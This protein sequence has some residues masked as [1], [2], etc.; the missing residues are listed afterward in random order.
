MSRSTSSCTCYALRNRGALRLDAG[1]GVRLDDRLRTRDQHL[2]FALSD[3]RGL[4]REVAQ[5]VELGATDAA[6]ANHLD[7]GDHGAVHREDA[8]DTNAARDLADGERGAHAAAAPGDA[9]TFESLE[10]F[11]VAFTD[12][13]VNT[14]GVTGAE[15]RDVSEPLFL[16]FNEGV[17]MTLGAGVNSLV[18]TGF[19]VC[20]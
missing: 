6:T 13:D 14:E 7:V 19:G 8:L 17:H 3:A 1:L 16:G 18:R 2:G 15:R 5:V 4:T 11:L 10:S 20:G 9:N 12:A